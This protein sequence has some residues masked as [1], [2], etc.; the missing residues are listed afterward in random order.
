MHMN[1]LSLLHSLFKH[2]ARG[3]PSIGHHREKLRQFAGRHALVPLRVT[4]N[5]VQLWIVTSQHHTGLSQKGLGVGLYLG[6]WNHRA[7]HIFAGWIADSGS[8]ISNQEH[9]L[10]S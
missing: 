8:G 6:W 4:A 9:D 2:V 5:L 7:Q 1:V 3:Q 10:V